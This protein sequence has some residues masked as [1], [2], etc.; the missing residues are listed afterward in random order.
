MD[1]GLTK[2]DTQVGAVGISDSRN[3]SPDITGDK[4]KPI[5]SEATV[6]L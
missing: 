6:E 4:H 1:P 2:T 3:G 5:A